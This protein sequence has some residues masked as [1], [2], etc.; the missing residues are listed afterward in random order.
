[1]ILDDN[2]RSVSIES[3]KDALPLVRV[4]VGTTIRVAPETFRF[5]ERVIFDCPRFPGITLRKFVVQ[6]QIVP[7]QPSSGFLHLFGSH[8]GL[9]P[10]TSASG[11]W[12]CLSFIFHRY[13][14]CVLLSYIIIIVFLYALK[15]RIRGKCGIFLL[16]MLFSVFQYLYFCFT[17]NSIPPGDIG[18]RSS[19]YL[20]FKHNFFKHNFVCF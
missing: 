7:G 20:G 19:I 9:K 8:D 5:P 16:S 1:M 10:S 12:P 17:E 18:F 3:Q 15:R 11:G 2:A 13:W 6:H 14:Y 4:P